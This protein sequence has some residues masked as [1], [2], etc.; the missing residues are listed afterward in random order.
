MASLSFVTSISLLLLALP[1]SVLSVPAPGPQLPAP[2]LVQAATVPPPDRIH[3]KVT[4][5]ELQS[6]KGV[7]P[8]GNSAEGE[9]N[10]LNIT[11]SGVNPG[12]RTIGCFGKWFQDAAETDG[13]SVEDFQCTDPAMQ[14]TAFE[15]SK[16]TPDSIRLTV[17]VQYQ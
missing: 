2:A 5:A 7:S 9:N 10:A 3:Y 1:T 8:E 15:Y 17:S 13:T 16:L 6:V 14:M 4:A 12:D 11:V